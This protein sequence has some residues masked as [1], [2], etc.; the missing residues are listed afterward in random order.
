MIDK[1]IET[2]RNYGMEIN[3]EKTKVMT[4]S[5][6]PFPVKLVI[7]QDKTGESRI[8]YLFYV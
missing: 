8:C 7:D 3:V 2:G 4:I 5:T 6:Q 1:L